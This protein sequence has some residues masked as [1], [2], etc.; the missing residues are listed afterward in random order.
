MCQF[1][2]YS[3]VIQPY[4]YV[5]VCIFFFRFFSLMGYIEYIVPAQIYLE[6]TFYRSIYSLHQTIP[7]FYIFSRFLKKIFLFYIGAQLINNVVNFR[8]T[9]NDSVIHIHV[10]ILFQILSYPLQHWLFVD[11]LIM[12][13]LTS[14]RQYFIIVFFFLVSFMVFHIHLIPFFKKFIYL[15]L[16]IYGCVGSSFLCEGLLQLWQAGA[17]PHRGAWASHY[18]GLSRCGAQAPDAQAQ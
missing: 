1:Q 14:V 15:F 10:S 8:C 5:C 12:A 4:I 7:S 18:R 6:L 17:P 3:K 2:V 9:A 13:I 11:F 16:F